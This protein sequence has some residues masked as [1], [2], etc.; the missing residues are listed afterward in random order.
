MTKEEAVRE[1]RKMWSWIASE[2]RR[3]WRCVRKDEYL[4]KF[5][6]RPNPALDCFCCEYG[7]LRKKY[8]QDNRCRYCPINW[9]S[10]AEH[11]PCQYLDEED[12]QNEIW[13]GL[14]GEW[15]LDCMRGDWEHAAD[16][17]DMIAELAESED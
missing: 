15:L 11:F 6:D 13:S 9:N 14:Y 17:A 1:H 3:L 2:S 7:Y 8:I 5:W 4:A 12:H 10:K 16:I